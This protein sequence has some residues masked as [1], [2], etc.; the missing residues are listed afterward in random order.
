[1]SV[2]LDCDQPVLKCNSVLKSIINDKTVIIHLKI[3]MGSI[4]S[5]TMILIS[6]SIPLF[7]L[8]HLRMCL[9]FYSHH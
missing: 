2:I 5:Q 9:D 7:G 3:P 4:V 1:M 8:L 6:Q